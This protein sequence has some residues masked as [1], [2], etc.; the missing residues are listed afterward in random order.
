MAAARDTTGKNI[1]PL[2]G[3]IVRRFAA[4]STIAP[5]ELVAMASD[6][7]ID[8]A[9]AASVAL[10]TVLGVALP[11]ESGGDFAAGDPVDVVVFGP[12]VCM[13]GATEG[14]LIYAT[15]TAGEPAETAGTKTSV[16]G[17]ALTETVLLVRPFQTSFS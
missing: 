15:D 11:N 3:A 7:A 13:T 6:A 10:A 9:N 14:A 4:G 2:G 17:I 16:A 12:V 8:P 1:K 5:G